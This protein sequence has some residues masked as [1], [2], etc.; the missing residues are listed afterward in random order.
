MFL[1]ILLTYFLI[2]LRYGNFALDYQKGASAYGTRAH[3]VSRI[4]KVKL[5]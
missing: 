5:A 2:I 3:T 1:P 4:A